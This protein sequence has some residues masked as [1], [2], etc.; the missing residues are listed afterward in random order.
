MPRRTREGDFLETHAGL[1]FDVKGLTH[2]PGHVVAFL[3]YYPDPL[4]TR[5]RRGVKYSK[6]YSLKARLK[7]LEERFPEFLRYDE[8]FERTMSEVP[9]SRIKTY[10][11]PSVY[12]RVLSKRRDLDPVEQDAV[13]F[14]DEIRREAGVPKES[15][16]VTGSVLVQLHRKDSDIDLVCYGSREARRVYSALGRLLEDPESAIEPY[17]HSGLRKLFA[18]R[19]KDTELPYS[20]FVR[21]EARK[22]LQGTYRGRDYYVRLLKG[23][24]EIP[25]R[26]GELRY[27]PMGRTE[28]TAV[29][30]DDSENI[31]T[32]CRYPL[33]E[34]HVSSGV[35]LPIREVVSFR[36]RFC[37]QAR[38]GE[39]VE[40]AGEV[41][42]VEGRLGV[43]YQLILGSHKQ[44][45]LK[46]VQS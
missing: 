11:E 9:V 15:I 45:F 46:V 25:Y 32:P 2:P 20:D 14:A 16:G 17:D 6:V 30:S 18:F 12:L 22:K 10:Y 26:Y 41:E 4:G 27:K 28:I 21:V 8:V 5:I 39:T 23:W 43:Y 19:K 31:F 24:V 1:I 36:G 13:D 33:R 37:E 44:D 34:V 3:R 29:V 7:L 35:D 42:R 38:K 40:A